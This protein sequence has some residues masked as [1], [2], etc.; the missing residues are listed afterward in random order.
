MNE[1]FTGLT[2]KDVNICL[3]VL[4]A[5]GIACQT[6]GHS[7]RFTLSVNDEDREIALFEIESYYRENNGLIQSPEFL[8]PPLDFTSGILAALVILAVHLAVVWHSGMTFFVKTFGASASSIL[9][10]EHYRIVTALMLH[11]GYPHLVGNM[12]GLILL[13]PLV[14]RL[15]GFGI[16]FLSILLSG[17]AGNYVNA[18][19]YQNDHLSIGASTSVFGAI[20]ILVIHRFA[21]ALNVSG[22]GFRPWMPIAS[23][24][25]LL[26]LLSSG[27]HTD[28]LAHFFGFCCGMAIGYGFHRVVK[29]P[30]DLF[31]QVFS[32]SVFL[33]IIFF[34][35]M[36]LW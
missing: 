1:L 13:V 6:S 4:A 7:N 3:T 30:P 34:S 18:H 21:D 5:A 35:W 26:G 33:I 23:G 11:S 20:G 15:H 32:F 36:R 29:T 14:S 22:I 9:D 2:E 31:Y 25:C 27:E 8:M 19:I 17:A 24:L 10:G 12:A 16:G 28:I